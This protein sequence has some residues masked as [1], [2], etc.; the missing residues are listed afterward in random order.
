MTKYKRRPMEVE[1][2]RWDGTEAS[3][4][5]VR[6][7]AGAA[8]LTVEPESS[9]DDDVDA[10]AA[11]RSDLHGG[12]WIGMRNGDYVVVDDEGRLFPLRAAIFEE[13]YEAW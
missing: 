8:F 10:T 1:A 11:C 6:L 3:A 2:V 4:D 7:L 13:T 5:I 12:R 9:W